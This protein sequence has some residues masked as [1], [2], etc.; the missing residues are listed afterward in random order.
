MRAG[1]CLH[2]PVRMVVLERAPASWLEEPDSAGGRVESI[3]ASSSSSEESSSGVWAPPL[4]GGQPAPESG[5][6]GV[7]HCNLHSRQK[8]LLSSVTQRCVYHLPSSDT[9]LP[10][11]SLKIPTPT[12]DGNDLARARPTEGLKAGAGH[13][14]VT[15]SH[16]SPVVLVQSLPCF[17]GAMLGAGACLARVRGCRMSVL[18]V[19]FI[20]NSIVRVHYPCGLSGLMHAHGRGQAPMAFLLATAALHATGEAKAGDRSDQRRATAAIAHR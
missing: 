8:E 3:L 2:I 16:H 6:R 1:W 10:L 20:Y 17:V 18:C 14:L 7:G 12:C 4:G 5:E 11:S 15:S 9:F 13:G 19:S